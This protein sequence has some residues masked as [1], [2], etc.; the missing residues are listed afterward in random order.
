MPHTIIIILYEMSEV[1]KDGNQ[2]EK[3]MR[4]ICLNDETDAPD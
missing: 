2:Q 4:Q 3:I 1:H